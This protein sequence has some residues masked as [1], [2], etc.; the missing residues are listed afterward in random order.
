MVVGIIGIS[1]F[2]VLT[3]LKGMTYLPQLVQVNA[4]FVITTCIARLA[5][6]LVFGVVSKTL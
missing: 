3:G 5:I 2:S 4:D 1:F 6:V